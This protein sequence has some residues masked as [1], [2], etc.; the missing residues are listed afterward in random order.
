MRTGR[1]QALSLRAEIRLVGQSRLGGDFLAVAKNDHRDVLADLGEAD[2]VDQVDV[3]L[4][5]HVVDV[6]M[7]SPERNSA[8]GG[9]VRRDAV[10]CAPMGRGRPSSAA[11][12]GPNFRS[13]SRPETPGHLARLDQLPADDHEHVDG[14][15]EADPL[16]AAG[17]AGD[18]RVDADD[19]AAEVD[20]RAAAV[21]GIDGGVGLQEVLER[22]RP[23]SPRLRGRGGPWR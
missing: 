3:V 17:V 23:A 9:R 6:R 22:G 21:A 8:F 19:L 4:H 15:G 2:Q 5:G 11:M 20:Q 18:G 12:A 10:T 13:D 1:N 16:V 14:D 7:T